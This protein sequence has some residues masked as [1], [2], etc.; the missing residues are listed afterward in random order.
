MRGRWLLPALAFACDA[1]EDVPPRPSA[2]IVGAQK[3]VHSPGELGVA[4]DYT[5]SVESVQPC[6][7][8]RPFRPE[9][10]IDKLGVEVVIEG[11]SEREVPV[12]P[13]Y[14]TLRDGTDETYS[15]T[16][17]GCRPVL[18]AVR[19]TRGDKAR[20]FITFDVPKSA[21]KLEMTYNPVVI[22]GGREELKFDLGR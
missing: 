12:N 5:M 14:A 9:P 10:G 8:E 3:P 19:V 17:A 2:E 21:R 16:L 6:A 7:V 22:G 13:F 15:S 1:S 20:G 11:K 4:R 18:E